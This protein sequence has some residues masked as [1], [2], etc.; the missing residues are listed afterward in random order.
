MTWGK[1]KPGHSC[2]GRKAHQ[3]TM[4]QPHPEMSDM[5]NGSRRG[6]SIRRRDDS[7]SDEKEDLHR[8]PVWRFFRHVLPAVIL[9]IVFFVYLM[10]GAAVFRYLENTNN[11]ATRFQNDVV[12]IK[13]ELYDMMTNS[14]A[15]DPTAMTTGVSPSNT[16]SSEIIRKSDEEPTER[17]QNEPMTSTYRDDHHYIRKGEV[18]RKIDEMIE[19]MNGRDWKAGRME[20]VQAGRAWSFPSAMLFCMTTITTIGYGDIVPLTTWGRAFCVVYSII[21]IPLSLICLANIG[22]LMARLVLK[23]CRLGHRI[24]V[25]RHRLNS[26]SC[27]SARRRSK[28]VEKTSS[29]KQ[30]VGSDVEIGLNTFESPPDYSPTDE[31]VKQSVP[32]TRDFSELRPDQPCTRSVSIATERPTF[33]PKGITKPETQ[34]GADHPKSCACE[35]E[36][37]CPNQAEPDILEE[38]PLFI[39][40]VILVVYMCAH[41]ALLSSSEDWTFGEGLY[42]SFITLTTIGFGDLVPTNHYARDS[43]IPCIFLTL[44]GLAIMSMCIALVQEKI[45]RTFREI[46]RKIGT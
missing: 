42:F 1:T 33:H 10:I 11:E 40:V 23:L 27:K 16:T 26:C 41:A 8:G 12:Q 43:F 7:V 28:V 32:A 15:I 35:C 36:C 18:D 6:I 38:V 9:L 25:I 5:G 45:L 22:N 20:A 24:L 31:V 17:G 21:G 13:T 2:A 37:Q 39:V 29:K 3:A 4:L 30:I 44:F 46:K 14:S 34:E 19:K